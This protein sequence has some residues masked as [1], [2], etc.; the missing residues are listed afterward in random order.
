MSSP[1]RIY[2]GTR[3]VLGVGPEVAIC[4]ERLGGTGVPQTALDDLDGLT[5]ANQQGRVMVAEVMKCRAWRHASGATRERTP[6]G[7]SVRRVRS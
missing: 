2:G 7:G 3:A 1:R 4:V 6:S 5:V